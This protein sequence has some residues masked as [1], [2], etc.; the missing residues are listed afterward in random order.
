MGWFPLLL[1][2]GV[3]FVVGAL[4]AA[5]VFALGAESVRLTP[6]RRRGLRVIDGGQP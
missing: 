6:A 5:W 2:F 4:A 3:G 1:G